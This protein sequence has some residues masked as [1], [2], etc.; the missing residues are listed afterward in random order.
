MLSL[1]ERKN[2]CAA[3][4]TSFGS[5]LRSSAGLVL[6]GA[7]L[8][9]IPKCPLCIVAYVTAFTGLGLSVGTAS[10]MRTALII[11]CL[12]AILFTVYRITKWT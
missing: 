12:A 6:P 4:R 3:G 7:A 2:C 11:L 8:L 5:K 1:T 10:D 9:V